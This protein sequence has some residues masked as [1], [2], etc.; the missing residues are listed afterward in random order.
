MWVCEGKTFLYRRES[1]RSAPVVATTSPWKSKNLPLIFMYFTFYLCGPLL[2]QAK[3]RAEEDEKNI[4]RHSRQWGL[5]AHPLVA[6]LMILDPVLCVFF[7]GRGADVRPPSFYL[8]IYFLS[9]PS[10]SNIKIYQ[11]SALQS[12]CFITVC[13][14]VYTCTY[15]PF[16]WLYLS[17]LTA[18]LCFYVSKHEIN[19]KSALEV[20]KLDF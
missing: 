20:A 4:H 15:I 16:T 13:V 12:S 11:A 19:G 9:I 8:F 6:L 17:S 10:F 1:T 14:C 3:V 5:V 18:C 2:L 7:Q